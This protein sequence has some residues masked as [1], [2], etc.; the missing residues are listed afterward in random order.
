MASELGKLG[1][2]SIGT[3]P[4]L[5]FRLI[6]DPEKTSAIAADGTVNTT[7]SGVKL[8]CGKDEILDPVEQKVAWAL[9]QYGQWEEKG[10]KVESVGNIL[11]SIE[12]QWEP[13]QRENEGFEM[14]GTLSRMFSR[15]YAE[16]TVNE[17]EVV[18]VHAPLRPGWFE[19]LV[20]W[21]YENKTLPLWQFIL[22]PNYA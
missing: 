21:D 22:Q 20:S 7:I 16:M 9:M 19:P 5:R 13:A 12:F 1:D 14:I 4:P 18:Q 11:K 2:R 10:P 17:H 3:R 6:A 15:Y 8:F